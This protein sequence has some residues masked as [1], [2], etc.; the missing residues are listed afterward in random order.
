[1]AAH[2]ADEV[3]SDAPLYET[4]LSVGL[5]E[6][7]V[8]PTTDDGSELQ[9]GRRL[10]RGEV[11]AGHRRAGLFVDLDGE[12][13]REMLRPGSA[14]VVDDDLSRSIFSMAS[15]PLTPPAA[16]VNVASASSPPLCGSARRGS[17]GCWGCGRGRRE[18][19]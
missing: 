14:V 8:V 17:A 18:G 4:P 5:L 19:D 1:M 7:V 2:V 13:G 3:G 6:A 16:P 11:R 12:I 9:A 15:P 10:E